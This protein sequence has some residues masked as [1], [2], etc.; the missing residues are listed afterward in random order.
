MCINKNLLFVKIRLNIIN[1]KW[2]NLSLRSGVYWNIALKNKPVRY[3]AGIGL[4]LFRIVFD[5]AGAI[6]SERVRIQDAVNIP[7]DVKLSTSLGL[8]F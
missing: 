2:L 1:K 5:I 6:S 3:T 8:T 7:T 4:N